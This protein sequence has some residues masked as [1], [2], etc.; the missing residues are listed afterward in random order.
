MS[1]KKSIDEK[2]AEAQ[3]KLEQARNQLKRLE[4]EQRDADRKARTHRLCTRGGLLESLVPDTIPLTD[5][6]FKIFLEKTVLTEYA[7]RI[8]NQLKAQGG[9]T[10]VPQAAETAGIPSAEGPEQARGEGA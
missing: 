6:Q 9:D 1:T 4:N 10:A 3:A 5:E 7:R 2:I 8:L